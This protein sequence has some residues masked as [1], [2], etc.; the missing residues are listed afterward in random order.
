MYLSIH[1]SMVTALHL[2]IPAAQISGT[3]LLIKLHTGIVKNEIG[4]WSINHFLRVIYLGKIPK[5][6]FIK[7]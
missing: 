5:T 4:I 2:F 3:L 1:S 6:P 7:T